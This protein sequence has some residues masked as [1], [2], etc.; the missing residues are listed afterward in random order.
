VSAAGAPE[1]TYQWWLA[2]G[3]DAAWFTLPP[4]GTLIEGATNATLSIPVNTTNAGQYYFVEVANPFG[5]VSSRSAT[6]S[7]E[8]PPW[9]RAEAVAGGQYRFELY[10]QPDRTYEISSRSTFRAGCTSPTWS[11]P[12]TGS[13]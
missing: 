3:W 2:V 9:L 7:L 13:S 6:L 5:V 10:G 11:P 8:S 4:M 12:I 1:L